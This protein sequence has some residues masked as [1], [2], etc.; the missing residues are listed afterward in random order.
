M[1]I[2]EAR[3][4]LVNSNSPLAWA[5]PQVYEAPVLSLTT[6]LNDIFLLPSSLWGTTIVPVFKFVPPVD[7]V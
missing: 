2:K 5:L 3:K 4:I 6:K 1:S 7:G